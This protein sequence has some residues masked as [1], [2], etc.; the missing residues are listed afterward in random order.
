[1]EKSLQSS[2]NITMFTPQTP[3]LI[4]AIIAQNVGKYE[5]DGTEGPVYAFTKK[6]DAEN[7]VEYLN[8]RMKE[9]NTEYR[10]YFVEI[11]HLFKK[12]LK[13]LF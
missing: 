13:P 7:T 11:I 4:Y 1:M 6:E 8:K 3:T 10:K 2:G 5:K 12:Q 9:Q